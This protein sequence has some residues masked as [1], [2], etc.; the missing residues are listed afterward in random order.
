MFLKQIFAQ[1]AKNIKFP[2]ATVRLIVPRLH[3]LYFAPLKNHIELYSAVLDESRDTKMKNLEA[4][5][6]KTPVNAICSFSI[7]ARLIYILGQALWA[8]T[9]S[10]RTNTIASPDQFKPMTIGE[11]L[12]VNNNT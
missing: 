12:V 10:P 11:N 5:T 2:G 3:C 8:E 6:D 9:V 1:E 7:L 4:K